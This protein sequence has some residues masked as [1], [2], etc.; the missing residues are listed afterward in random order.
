MAL[1]LL[2]LRLGALLF[3]LVASVA[4][5]AY[6]AAM[7]LGRIAATLDTV[8]NDR[9]ICMRQ[10]RDVHDVYSYVIPSAVQQFRDGRM[11]P[12][13]ALTKISNARLLATSQWRAYTLT[14]L[15][16]KEE[17]QLADTRNAELSVEAATNRLEE[18]LAKADGAGVEALATGELPV[19]I[20]SLV[21]RVNLLSDI[22]VEVSR[23]EDK[24]AQDTYHGTM[25]W[26]S[27]LAGLALT[28]GAALLWLLLFQR[29]RQS[30][31][32][33]R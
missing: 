4:S 18:L 27:L 3:V 17:R 7:R 33:A 2:K 12:G 10:L 29:T 9:V 30:A 32:P 26:L 24:L 13:P 8:F 21:S 23:D 5:I 22:Q 19:A 6:L 16:A 15:S 1:S 25:F 20:E 14:Q 31:P 28:A 11:K